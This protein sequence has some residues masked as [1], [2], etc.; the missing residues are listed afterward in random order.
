MHKKLLNHA[1]LRFSLEPRGP[2]LIKSGLETPDPTRPGMEFVRTRH[3]RLG[4]TVYLPGSSLKGAL[5]GQAERALAGQGV[6]VCDPLDRH[7]RCRSPGRNAA[8]AEVYRLQCPACRTFGSLAVGGRCNVLDAYPWPP[9]AEE[10]E[11]IAAAKRANAT[12][13][14][15]QVAIDRTSGAAHGGGLFDIEVVVAGRFHTELLLESFQLWQLGLLAAVLRD[16]DRGDVPIGFGKSRGLG[17]MAVAWEG[18]EIETAGHEPRRLEGAAGLL[19]AAGRRQYGL[20][21]G[22]ALDLPPGVASEATWRGRRLEARGADLEA[23]LDAAIAGP[24]TTYASRRDGGR[25]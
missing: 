23:L 8:T 19:S 4:D 1:R 13:R 9:D 2:V 25:A 14:R 18:L 6:A 21:D 7:H 10:A 20:A 11:Q 15:N 22:D 5:R 12:D 17:Q 3:S 16:V 24:L